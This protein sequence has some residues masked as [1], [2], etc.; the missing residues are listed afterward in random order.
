MCESYESY[1]EKKNDKENKSHVFVIFSDSFDFCDVL[2]QG[3][4]I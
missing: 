3:F 1:I 4:N 2:T